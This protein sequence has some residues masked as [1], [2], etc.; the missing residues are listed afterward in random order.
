MANN[1]KKSNSSEELKKIALRYMQTLTDVARESFLIVDDRLMVVSA[2]DIFYKT[3][4]VNPKDTLGKYLYELGNGQWD[5]PELKK[6]LEN[7][8]PDKKIVKNYEVTHF[9]ETIEQKTMLLNAR[10]VDAIQLI[11]LAIEDIT[12]KKNLEKKLAQHTK[13]LEVKV[14][15]RTKELSKRIKELEIL[16]KS[17]VGRE[18]KMMDL[19]RE[20]KGLK[21]PVKNG[22]SKS[23]KKN[24][25]H[26]K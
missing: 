4:Q 5:I 2:N 7:I 14:A 6:L 11:I 23:G 10:Q 1:N 12:D 9:F 19:K 25:N 20:I 21:K 8:L 13:E 26:K 18:L 22:N 15:E 16:N 3:F 17:M 24:G